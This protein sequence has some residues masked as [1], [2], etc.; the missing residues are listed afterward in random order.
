MKSVELAVRGLELYVHGNAE[1]LIQAARGDKFD[2]LE[3]ASVLKKVKEEKRLQVLLEKA[4][5]DQY[6]R[7]TKEVRSEEKWVWFQNGDWKRGTKSLIV[8]VQ[9]QI[10]RT[11]LVKA[12]IDKSQKDMLCRMCKKADESTDHFVSGCRKLA[13]KEYKGRHDNLGKIVHWNLLE[14]VI[15]LEISGMNMSQKVF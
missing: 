5:H 9:N 6:L 13:Q 8:A 10:I 11:N 2:G 1:R 14:S 15:K 4:L 3:V 12:K 7:Q